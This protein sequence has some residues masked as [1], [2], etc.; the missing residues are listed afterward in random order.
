MEKTFLPGSRF[1]D[2]L[3]NETSLTL[4]VYDRRRKDGMKDYS[5]ATYDFGFISDTREE[6]AGLGDFFTAR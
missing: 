3:S 5:L 2:N 6:L 4:G 1:I